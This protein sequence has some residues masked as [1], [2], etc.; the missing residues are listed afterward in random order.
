MLERALI[1]HTDYSCEEVDIEIYN[2]RGIVKYG[3]PVGDKEFI[4]DQVRPFIVKGQG[5]FGKNKILYLLKHDKLRPCNFVVEPTNDKNYIEVGFQANGSEV[6]E[7]LAPFNPTFGEQRGEFKDITPDKLRQT[8]DLSFM[9]HLKRYAI[10]GGGGGF[11]KIGK[12]KGVIALILFVV[13]FAITTL[14][15]YQMLGG[16]G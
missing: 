6:R 11:L 16:F 12:G 8:F 1:F 4:L 9:K 13:I 10:D 5:M 14:V 2:G 15:S 7:T 3:E